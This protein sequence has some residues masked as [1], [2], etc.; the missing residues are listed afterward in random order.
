MA[1]ISLSFLKGTAQQFFFENFGTLTA[2]DQEQSISSYN[3][4]QYGPPVSYAGTA[5]VSGAVNS[6]GYGNASGFGNIHFEPSSAQYLTISGINTSGYSSDLITLSFGYFKESASD[7]DITL[8]YSTN[9]TNFTPVEINRLNDSGWEAVHINNIIP[10]VSNLTVRF[11]QTSGVS[12]R[13]DDLRFR[14]GLECPLRISTISRNCNDNTTGTDTYTAY[15]PF[16]GGGTQSYGITTSSGTIMGDNPS[17]QEQGV[18]QI[19]N[20]E[21]GRT[22]NVNIVGNLC[23]YG[24]TLAGPQCKPEQ[25]IPFYDSFDYTADASLTN[26][27]GWASI[28]NGGILKIQSGSLT[29]PSMP[30][31][32]NSLKL[33]N[34][35]RDAYIKFTPTSSGKVFASFIFSVESL[36]TLLAEGQS[37]MVNAFSESQNFDRN[38]LRMYVQKIGND[39]KIGISSGNDAPVYSTETYSLNENQFVI[40]GYDFSTNNV[41][42]WINPNVSTINDNTPPAITAVSS[43]TPADF[44]SFCVYQNV[45]SYMDELKIGTS[46]SVVTTSILANNAVSAKEFTIS[47]NPL[48]GGN[49]LNIQSAQNGTKLVAIYD[50]MGKQVFTETTA[51]GTIAP[52]LSTGLYMVKVT[53]NN[54]ST[55]KKLVVN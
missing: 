7:S 10:S 50:M 52:Q 1:F 44:G 54:V 53:E 51:S 39:Y 28:M 12:F 13:I 4:F 18:I 6:I 31:N 35:G 26:Y 3:G 43:V 9:G 45:V 55:V 42:A 41:M 20:V 48:T 11:T 34:S 23:D 30:S 47:P 21:E 5:K 19:V 46:L 22:L 15:I 16:N 24:Y 49:V 40:V 27:A 17:T 36:A 37:T 2:T 33:N 32:G 14:T 29:H 8:E 38:T 25:Q